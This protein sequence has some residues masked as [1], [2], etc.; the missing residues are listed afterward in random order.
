MSDFRSQIESR[1]KLNPCHHNLI[2]TL[3]VPQNSKHCFCWGTLK[4]ILNLGFSKI[5]VA[6]WKK[7]VLLGGGGC[8]PTFFCVLLLLRVLLSGQRMVLRHLTSVWAWKIIHD[9]FL[10]ELA[11]PS[12][13]SL[14]TSMYKEGEM[15]LVCTRK[16]GITTL[17]R[18]ISQLPEQPPV[19]SWDAHMILQFLHQTTATPTALDFMSSRVLW[20]CKHTLQPACCRAWALGVAEKISQGRPA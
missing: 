5:W 4:S 1:F 2:K 17:L 12:S 13:K 16:A 19:N 8:H 6:N 18:E 7:T 15:P 20:L 9:Y 10:L 3:D 14:L 11:I